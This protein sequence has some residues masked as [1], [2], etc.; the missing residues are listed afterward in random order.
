MSIL[1]VVSSRWDK[2]SLVTLQLQSALCKP[3][4]SFMSASVSYSSSTRYP[5]SNDDDHPSLTN[6]E[7]SPIQELSNDENRCKEDEKNSHKGTGAT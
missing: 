1:S 6:E 4:Y 2:Y 3:T 5:I 7:V